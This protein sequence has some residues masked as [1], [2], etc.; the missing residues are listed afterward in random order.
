[1][2]V[3]AFGMVL[4]ELLSRRLLASSVAA[5]C[6][7]SSSNSRRGSSK[8]RKSQ[9]PEQQQQQLPTQ[10]MPLKSALS[11]AATAES[12]DGSDG[13]GSSSDGGGGTGTAATTA[14]AAEC[15]RLPE[16]QLLLM[17]AQLVA[18][19]YRPP[20]LPHFPEP[21]VRLIS[22]CWAAEPHE[23]PRMAEV[24]QELQCWHKD[25]KVL[26]P[27]NSY[28]LALA[29]IGYGRGSGGQQPGCSC[30]IS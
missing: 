1:V 28:V 4:Y 20:M 15:G 9:G 8:H 18:G 29:D 12:T 22:S 6:S 27:L 10:P 24:L 19:G 26:G 21:V 3:F 7:S 14:A 30:V 13:A 11:N 5:V 2:D 16:H 17:Y 23:R 25:R